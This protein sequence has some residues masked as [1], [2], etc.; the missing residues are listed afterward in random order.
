M[1]IVFKF[2]NFIPLMI[3]SIHWALGGIIIFSSCANQGN[4]VAQQ[5]S[6]SEDTTLVFTVSPAMPFELTDPSS[7]EQAAHF[8][9]EEFFA[10]TWPAQ[11]QGPTLFPRGLP[12]TD[13]KYGGPGPTGQLV[14]ET[15]RQKAEMYPGQGY[16]N[17]FDS[18]R[19][20]FGFGARPDYRYAG[21]MNIP[22]NGEVPPLYKDHD[23]SKIPPFNNLDEVTQID[24]NAMYAGRSLHTHSGTNSQASE[25]KAKIL[26]E[27][28]VN[29]IY[30]KYVAANRYFQSDSPAISNIIFNSGSF[31]QTGDSASY[32][33][34]YTN[35]PM[36]DPSKKINGSIE[37]K[38]TWRR[39]DPK[40][41]DVSKFYTARVRYYSGK[42]VNGEQ[43]VIQGYIDN[44]DPEVKEVYGLIALHIIQK[45]PNAPAFIYA[46]FSHFDNILD[47]AGKSVEDADGSTL[48]PYLNQQPFSPALRIEN[49][50]PS[51]PQKVSIVSGK[52]NTNSPQL[53]FINVE[54]KEVI[55]DSTGKKYFGPVNINRRLFPIPPVIVSANKKA[56]EAI[57]AV[58]PN[59]VWLN[60]KLVNVQ[61]QPLDYIADSAKIHNELAP[62][63]FLANEVVETNPSLQQFSGGLVNAGATGQIA[64]YNNGV[65]IHN[66]YIRSV[67]PSKAY[68]MGGCMG[69]HGSQGQKVGG[70]FSVLLARGRVS[71]PE[72][73][74]ENETQKVLMF[75]EGLKYFNKPALDKLSNKKTK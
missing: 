3:K 22:A 25:I 71:T 16:P 62:T 36:S 19:A 21:I 46:T 40:T 49:S 45:T 27:A 58:N 69:C 74:Q 18:T 20:D 70:D 24:L 9:W 54:G 4:E 32:P 1:N 8:A 51:S 28:K 6:S 57:K 2:P 68:N 47:S 15:F 7:L 42:V 75:I 14:W 12:Q 30:Y 67:T 37:I 50:T 61:A 34:P 73:I 65:Y 59:A 72:I 43:K 17:G 10:A 26:F 52:A 56:H 13:G 39:L 63:Y 29:E 5:A 31:A 55:T 41:E 23:T 33:P 66:T 44:D 64:N 53:Y 38:A 35:L 11:A 48:P 60:Y